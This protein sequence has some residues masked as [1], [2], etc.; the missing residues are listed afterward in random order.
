MS[1]LR[2]VLAALSS[3]AILAA[4]VIGAG[5]ALQQGAAAESLSG[6]LVFVTTRFGSIAQVVTAKPDGS[7]LKQLTTAPGQ[8]YAPS[9]SPDGTMILFSSDRDN[10]NK[11]FQIYSM[12]VDGSALK[13]L[14]NPP[15]NAGTPTWSPDGKVIAFAATV[16]GSQR[17][18]IYTASADGSNLRQQT[19]ST[20]ASNASPAFSPDGKEIAYVSTRTEKVTLPN[21]T[22]VTGPKQQVHIM[23]NFSLLPSGSS[24]TNTDQAI[25]MAGNTSYPQ[26]FDQTHLMVTSASTDGATAQLFLY[27]AVG[28]AIKP[29]T[30]AG[31]YAAEAH[32]DAVWVT[33]TTIAPQGVAIAWMPRGGGAQ[34]VLA[35]G[36]GDNYSGTYRP[37]IATPASA[38]PAP[39]TGVTGAPSDGRGPT[40]NIFEVMTGMTVVG[41]AVGGLYYFVKIR[42]KKDGCDEQRKAVTGARAEFA[43]ASAAFD[44]AEAERDRLLKIRHAADA[45]LAGYL[46]D[47]SGTGAQLEHGHAAVSEATAAL[48]KAQAVL[49]GPAYYRVASARSNLELAEKR[50]ADCEGAAA[51]AAKGAAKAA[52]IKGALEPDRD[53]PSDF[54]KHLPS[55]PNTDDKPEKP[56]LKWAEPKTAPERPAPTAPPVPPDPPTPPARP[57]RREPSRVGR[58][59]EDAG[60]R[61]TI[62]KDG[63]EPEPPG[64]DEPGAEDDLNRTP[65][66]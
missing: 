43:A 9:L 57:E 55:A 24:P 64:P 49:S 18:D 11:Q 65:I 54:K 32:V 5:L 61:T 34:T 59:D 58:G 27:D 25:A 37:L 63:F 35:L 31:T 53:F 36:P 16:P 8:S 48:E 39:L 42:K 4:A 14:T 3:G 1:R 52:A 12:N 45:E 62:V 6:R 7:D 29:F 10:P 17:F 46:K 23:T 40:L 30:P 19:I 13:R 26:Y 28:L 60:P 20:D 47:G 33:Y 41:V 38:V 51:A 66:T 44:A 21:G 22:T 56:W 50:L 2:Q 15:L